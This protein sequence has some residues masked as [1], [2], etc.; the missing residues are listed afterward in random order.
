LIAQSRHRSIDLALFVCTKGC[1]AICSCDASA[2]TE[3]GRLCRPVHK[4]VHRQRPHFRHVRSTLG[5][6]ACR[7]R[8]SVSASPSRAARQDAAPPPTHISC[9]RGSP[10]MPEL[11]PGRHRPGAALDDLGVLNDSRGS[12]LWEPEMGANVFSRPQTQRDVLRMFVQVMDSQF[13]S[14]RR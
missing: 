14:V 9:G 8:P 11:R 12:R 4:H 13:D 10:A 1:A 6:S 3:H 2:T 5:P 7:P